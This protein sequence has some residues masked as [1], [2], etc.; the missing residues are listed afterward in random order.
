MKTTDEMQ[1]EADA[2]IAAAGAQTEAQMRDTKAPWP[3][4]EEELLAYVK[5]LVDR[6]HDYGTCVY[7][8][9]L[10]AVAAFNFIAARL[11]TTGFQASCA[12]MDIIRRTRG[13]ED[14]FMILDASNLLYPQYDLIGK[15]EKFI[16]ERRVDL[17]KKA[18]Q[19]LED[20]K[21]E[22]VSERVVQHWRDLAS[23]DPVE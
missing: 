21:G 13:M 8:M 20:R 23:L 6:P 10:A 5:S 12:D 2:K 3:K 14:G 17:A 18:R 22:P 7:A 9:S 4:T 1:A 11:G 15:A 19:L 16:A